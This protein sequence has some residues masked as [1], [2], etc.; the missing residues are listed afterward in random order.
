MA[1]GISY[2]IEGDVITLRLV[3]DYTLDA[4]EELLRRALSDARAPLVAKVLVDG[5]LSTVRRTSPEVRRQADFLRSLSQ[6]ISQLAV[7]TGSEVHYGIGRMG[8]VFADDGKLDIRIFRAM[9]DALSWLG[10]AEDDTASKDR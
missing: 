1:D 10:I 7:V 9:S 6:R 8:A 4:Y 5:T 3:G 2:R